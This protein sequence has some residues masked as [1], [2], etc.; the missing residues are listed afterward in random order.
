MNP[1]YSLQVRDLAQIEWSTS[2]PWDELTSVEESVFIP[3][4]SGQMY[5]ENRFSVGSS[6]L[7]IQPC[8]LLGAK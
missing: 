1:I 8:R 5:V 4:P 2:M 6:T 7:F 3:T